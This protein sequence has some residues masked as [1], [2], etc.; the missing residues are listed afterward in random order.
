V[1]CVR[2]L[3]R[4]DWAFLPGSW[5]TRIRRRGRRD[6]LQAQKPRRRW[7]PMLD[8]RS[9]RQRSQ[10]DALGLRVRE[11]P[12]VG[13]VFHTYLTGPIYA[14]PALRGWTWRSPRA[15]PWRWSS[16]GCGTSTLRAQR[17]AQCS[18]PG[19]AGSRLRQATL[20]PDVPLSSFA[21]Q[22]GAGGCRVRL[23]PDLPLRRRRHVPTAPATKG[24]SGK[25]RGSA[26]AV[27]MEQ[28]WSPLQR[29]QGPQ[30]VF[31]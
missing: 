3:R 2:D 27:L 1:L 9:R 24:L 17:Q 19:K 4:L 7:M 15:C 25:A 30:T 26:S 11:P 23:G 21:D 16:S 12:F 10:F 28:A 5:T 13:I 18:F 20:D 6:P 8:E 14:R 29:I 31:P 22:G